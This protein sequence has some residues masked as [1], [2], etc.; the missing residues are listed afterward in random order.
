MT[1]RYIKIA[2]VIL[3]IFAGSFHASAQEFQENKNPVAVLVQLKS[4]KRRIDALIQSK[5]MNEL[6]RFRKEAYQCMMATVAD[7]RD[8]FAVRPVYFYIDTN[9]DAV[10]QRKFDGILLDSS[11]MPATDINIK[12]DDYF[13]IANYGIAQWQTNKRKWDTT[14]AEFWG[15]K[16]NGKAL[17]INDPK[18]R[19]VAYITTIDYDFFNFQKQNKK[20]PYKFRSKKYNIGYEPC[21]AEF[22][23]RLEKHYKS[24]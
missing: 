11:L 5:R 9:F 2:I 3:F 24:R 15:G 6:E 23:R 12:P 21:A 16:P 4:E 1:A 7:F 18:M 8:H 22:N 20:N 13:L 14:K 17:N 10:Q 19:Q